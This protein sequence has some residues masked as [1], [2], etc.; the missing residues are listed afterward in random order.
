MSMPQQHGYRTCIRSSSDSR[1]NRRRE[2]LAGRKNLLCVLAPD[3]TATVG[4]SSKALRVKLFNGLEAVPSDTDLLDADGLAASYAR[5]RRFSSAV[6][7]RRFI[8]AIQV[9]GAITSRR[10]LPAN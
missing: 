6:E 1:I 5:R 2:S 9:S 3:R 10:G 4:E 7:K 8:A